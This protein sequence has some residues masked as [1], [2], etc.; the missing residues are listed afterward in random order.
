MHA[1]L[2]SHEAKHVC[3]VEQLRDGRFFLPLVEMMVYDKHAVVHSAEWASTIGTCLLN[4]RKLR[5]SYCSRGK[6]LQTF[7]QLTQ[8]SMG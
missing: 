2:L 6:H 7:A 1:F 5:I 3:E 8:K 4:N